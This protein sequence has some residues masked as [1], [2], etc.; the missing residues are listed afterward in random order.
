MT[1]QKTYSQVWVART[2]LQQ[3]IDVGEREFRLRVLALSLRE[4]VPT[5]SHLGRYQTSV[6]QGDAGSKRKRE[7]RLD[8]PP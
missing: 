4:L 3:F 5:E 1:F 6:L 8:S 7:K 2:L